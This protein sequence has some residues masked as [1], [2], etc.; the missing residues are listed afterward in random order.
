[1]NIHIETISFGRGSKQRDDTR[2]PSA[3]PALWESC[4]LCKSPKLS[5]PQFPL[6][7]KKKKDI[8]L[9]V[10]RLFNLDNKM[11]AVQWDPRCEAQRR[12]STS[13]WVR[14]E[15]A[16]HWQKAPC[17]P[18][19]VTAALAVPSH[20]ETGTWKQEGEPRDL[21]QQK[22][23]PREDRNSFAMMISQMLLSLTVW[24]SNF[25]SMT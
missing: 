7:L 15:A 1:M 3:P 8:L 20:L 11:Q 10:P 18:W 19:S 6:L 12:P 14:E 4:W 21:P 24:K 22:A 17:F 23:D 9:P 13:Q 25:L 2:L 5:E 16:V